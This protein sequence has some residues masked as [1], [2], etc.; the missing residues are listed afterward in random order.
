MPRRVQAQQ[1]AAAD[2]AAALEASG[3]RL[4]Q[5]R[6][7]VQQDRAQAQQLRCASRPGAE[8]DGV[9]HLEVHA[10]IAGSWPA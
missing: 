8:T 7:T 3:S 4:D 5:D 6:A 1:Q 10:S 9:P 2:R